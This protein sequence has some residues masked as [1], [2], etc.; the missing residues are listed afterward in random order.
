MFICLYTF[1]GRFLRVYFYLVK[2]KLFWPLKNNIFLMLKCKHSSWS[3]QLACHAYNSVHT[4]KCCIILTKYFQVHSSQTVYSYCNNNMLMNFN[5]NQRA[6]V[7][8]KLIKCFSVYFK[9]TIV[10]IY[11]SFNNW[12]KYPCSTRIQFN[13]ETNL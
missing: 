7:M 11:E 3:T 5:K 2:Q 12:Y 8:N 6:S 10:L 9:T 4:Y 1:F 13:K